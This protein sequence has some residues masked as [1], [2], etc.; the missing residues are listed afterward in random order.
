MKLCKLVVFLC[1]LISLN[2]SAENDLSISLI[3]D[4]LKENANAV[5]QYHNTEWEVTSVGKI[6]LKVSYAVSILNA[7][8]RDYAKLIVSYDKKSE[9]SDLEGRRYNSKGVMVKKL[10]RDEIKDYSS[11]EDYTFYSDSRIKYAD[12]S[13]NTYPYTITY[14]YEKTYN[15]LINYQRWKPQSGFHISVISA[16]LF[17]NINKEMNFR[18]K[19]INYPGTVDQVNAGKTYDGYHWQVK[20]LKAVRKESFAPKFI[21]FSPMVI[22]APIEFKYHYR[23]GD[24]TNWK[25]YGQWAY[26]LLKGRDQLDEATI[27]EIKKLT[28]TISTDYMK[29][30][31]IYE[32]MQSKTRYVNISLGIGGFQPMTASEVSQCGYG[33]CKALS[34]YTK[35]LLNVVGIK[36]H[37]AEIGNGSYQKILFDDFATADQTNHIILC[38]PF[39]NDTVWLECTSQNIP[40]G[41]I[42]AGNSDRKAL[43]ITED[44]G[45]LV[46]TLHYEA[47]KNIRIANTQIDIDAFGDIQYE[48]NV[49][50]KNLAYYNSSFLLRKSKKDLYEYYQE[51]IDLTNLDIQSIDFVE[52]KKS[53]PSFDLKMIAKAEKFT[54]KIGERILIPANPL[55]RQSNI[56][57]SKKERYTDITF[58]TGFVEKDNYQI[59]LPDGFK[60]ESLPKDVKYVCEVG[61]YHLQFSHDTE[62]PNVIIVYREFYL[63][64][65]TYDK[66]NYSSIAKFFKSIARADKKK[67]I[68]TK[69]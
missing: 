61:S 13:S 9:I 17:F 18:H 36:A 14:S 48:T 40:F 63:K 37:Y 27:S 29:A 53:E 46:N 8:G 57:R 11:F 67:I 45:I 41:F 16:D 35:S 65:G 25:T 50:Y 66:S 31:A 1:C 59:K 2:V 44:G 28:D 19:E 34:N 54:S 21:G 33:D 20:N 58:S 51:N 3:P 69:S 68:L 32:Y 4:S 24:F 22:L 6:K 39:E 30:K 47:T 42:G 52:H 43:L 5:Y 55:N 49:N 26:S 23:K 12:L 64:D 56:F 60:C 15:G 62:N 7:Q 10:K 38:V